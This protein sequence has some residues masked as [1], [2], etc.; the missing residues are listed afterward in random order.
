MPESLSGVYEKECRAIPVAWYPLM[1]MLGRCPLRT[2]P[3]TSLI[4]KTCLNNERM[5]GEG[6]GAA[7]GVW[8][9][10]EF[11]ARVGIT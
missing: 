6:S 4:V 1:R 8:G 2:P 11:T 3:H 10:G 7:A 9:L 5:G